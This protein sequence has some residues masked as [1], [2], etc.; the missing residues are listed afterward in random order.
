MARRERKLFQS[1][2][3]DASWIRAECETQLSENEYKAL[4]AKIERQYKQNEQS[5]LKLIHFY[6]QSN[7]ELG[8]EFDTDFK[9]NCCYY[10]FYLIYYY[11][12][13]L[14]EGYLLKYKMASVIIDASAHGKNNFV[15]SVKRS[16][17]IFFIETLSSQIF[18]KSRIHLI[19]PSFKGWLDPLLYAVL[20]A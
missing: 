20:M 14:L 5:K 9:G 6:L 8:I 16:S 1:V 3:R 10:Y 17:Y 11:Y 12:Y 4:D 13:F 18:Q 7:T 15:C 19:A 2:E